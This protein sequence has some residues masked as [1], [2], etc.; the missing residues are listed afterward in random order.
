MALE[1]TKLRNLTP[2]ELAKEEHELREGV[3]KLRLRTG[4]ESKQGPDHNQVVD[5]RI[6]YYGSRGIWFRYAS[7]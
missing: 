6:H 1:M 2:D 3:W 7:R 4:K 5:T